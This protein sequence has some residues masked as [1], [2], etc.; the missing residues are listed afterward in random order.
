[1]KTVVK[2]V[3]TAFDKDEAITFASATAKLPYMLACFDEAMRIYP[4]V[5][6][7]LPRKSPGTVVAGR[8]VS[9]GVSKGISL[10]RTDQPLM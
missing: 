3:R 4:P 1:M 10:D 6:S 5:P 2:E 8:Y 7:A 9:A